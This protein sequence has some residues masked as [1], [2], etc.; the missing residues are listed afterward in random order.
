MDDKNPE[1]IPIKN[2]RTEDGAH[3][4]ATSENM[5]PYPRLLK[6]GLQSGRMNTFRPAIP[7]LSPF[8]FLRLA[9]RHMDLLG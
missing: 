7:D 3:E 9:I 8:R 2:L 6:A 4:L 1:S 5:Q